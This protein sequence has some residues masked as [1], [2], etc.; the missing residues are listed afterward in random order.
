MYQLRNSKTQ[1]ISRG[2]SVGTAT[3]HVS[4]GPGIESRWQRNIPHLSVPALGPTQSL[5]H[6]VQSLFAAGKSAGAWCRP[7]PSSAEVKERIQLYVYSPSGPSWSVLRWSLRFTATRFKTVAPLQITGYRHTNFERCSGS[8]QPSAVTK[9][10]NC[11][12]ATRP[13]FGI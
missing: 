11:G 1:Q 4:D 3:G 9:T 5:K 12:R 13:I 8:D 2:S 7:T 6:W 10:T